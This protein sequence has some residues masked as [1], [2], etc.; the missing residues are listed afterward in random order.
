M[1]APYII[2]NHLDEAGLAHR[3]S[4]N[5]QHIQDDRLPRFL[6]YFSLQCE[7]LACSELSTA[8]ALVHHG[9]SL[10]AAL[11]L[12]PVAQ[13]DAL[14]QA[15]EPHVF[16]LRELLVLRRS[17]H[18]LRGV[19]VFLDQLEDSL[20]VQLLGVASQYSVGRRRFILRFT[21]Y[22]KTTAKALCSKTWVSGGWSS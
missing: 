13:L 9:L 15:G 6:V 1:T 4:A 11:Q 12:P 18:R 5:H 14:E 21:N 22:R 19:L 10:L 20:C 7:Y 8:A 16:V 2:E 17:V 3:S